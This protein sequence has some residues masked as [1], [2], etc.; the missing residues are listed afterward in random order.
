MQRIRSRLHQGGRV[1]SQGHMGGT[2]QRERSESRL[3]QQSAASSSMIG[4]S[5]DVPSEVT[6]PGPGLQNENGWQ[7]TQGSVLSGDSSISKIFPSRRYAKAARNEK[8]T[9]VFDP[10]VELSQSL[11]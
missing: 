4:G 11:W 8:Q 1:Q 3:T 7:A 10:V 2:Q 5:L 9:G 6:V